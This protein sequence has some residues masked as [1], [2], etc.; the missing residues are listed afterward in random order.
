MAFF[1]FIHSFIYSLLV[2]LTHRSSTQDSSRYTIHTSKSKNSITV[3]IKHSCNKVFITQVTSLSWQLSVVLASSQMVVLQ[4]C[5]LWREEFMEC[6][7]YLVLL[8]VTL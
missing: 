1:F 4:C 6:V 8:S 5:G 2:Q 3:F 7:K